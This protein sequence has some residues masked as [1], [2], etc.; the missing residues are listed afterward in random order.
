MKSDHIDKFEQRSPGRRLGMLHRL[1]MSCMAGPLKELGISRGKVGFL[2]VLLRFDGIVQ[3]ELSN[4]LCIDRAATARALLDMEQDGL[5]TR[6]PDPEDRR[7]KRV[8][9]TAKSRALHPRLLEILAWHNEVLFTGLSP[10]E[11]DQFLNMLD[12]L[13]ENLKKAA[14]GDKA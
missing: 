14:L 8:Y 4:H 10:A 2:M 9:L 13:V 11:E 12:R 3:E 5:V 6:K 1:S 7:K